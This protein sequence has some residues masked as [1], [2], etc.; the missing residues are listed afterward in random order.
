MKIDT[1]LYQLKTNP[2]SF[3]SN[4]LL[5]ISGVG[6]SGPKVFYFCYY[7]N[8]A[9]GVN[10]GFKMQ[11]FP[12][13]SVK[14]GIDGKSYTAIRVQNVRMNP[15][16]EDLDVSDIEP[17]VL[18]GTGAD[19]M[20]TGQLSACIFCVRQEAGRLI[21]AHI[22][23]GGKRQ[24]GKTLR[25]TLKLMGRFNGGNRITHV[26]GLGD[27]PI[28]AHVVGLRTGGTWRLYAQ[29]INSGNGPIQDSV[30]II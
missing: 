26:F 14:T 9:P 5:S 1:A 29:R 27:Y 11:S 21:V 6:Q 24:T 2:M 8:I 15:N 22:Q 17:Y 25:Q 19:V 28:R 20:V 3:L 30:Q 16:T 12:N 23:P 10:E 13:N 7:D 18:D 4:N